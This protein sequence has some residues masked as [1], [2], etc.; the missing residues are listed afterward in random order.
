[1]ASESPASNRPKRGV[2]TGGSGETRNPGGSD[3]SMPKP[4]PEPQKHVESGFWATLLPALE[5]QV[6]LLNVKPQTLNP[7]VVQACLVS[8]PPEATVQHFADSL[9]FEVESK[10]QRG[11]L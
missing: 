7:K 3:F 1:M 9:Y 6:T 5:V 4:L 2:S 8:G 11:V 10:L